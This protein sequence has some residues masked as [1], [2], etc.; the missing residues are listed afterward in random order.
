M[1][2][3]IFCLKKSQLMKLMG[4]QILGRNSHLFTVVGDHL[5]FLDI[6]FNASMDLFDS[7]WYRLLTTYI[8]RFKIHEKRVKEESQTTQHQ[9]AQKRCVNCQTKLMICKQSRV[10]H[11]QTTLLTF[12]TPDTCFNLMLHGHFWKFYTS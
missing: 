12:N 10:G 2:T 9:T 8:Q 1:E 3:R 5:W 11:F 7:T 6:L 4:S